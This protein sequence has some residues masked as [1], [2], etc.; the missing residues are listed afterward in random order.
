MMKFTGTSRV[1]L[2]ATLL[3]LFTGNTNASLSGLYSTGGVP[4]QLAPGGYGNGLQQMLLN[5]G[6]L[7][8]GGYSAYPNANMLL[9]GMNGSRGFVQVGVLV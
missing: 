8:Q 5:N 6:A 7:T 1:L 3:L 4:L 2:V 9:G